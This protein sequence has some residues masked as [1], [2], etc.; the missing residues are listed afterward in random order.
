MNSEVCAQVRG[1]MEP[2]YEEGLTKENQG[3]MEACNLG[4]P[5]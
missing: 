1:I 4:G 5:V 3:F 2:T